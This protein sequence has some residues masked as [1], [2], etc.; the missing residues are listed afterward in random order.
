MKALK[1]DFAVRRP[2]GAWPWAVAISVLSLLTAYQGWRAWGPQARVRVLQEEHESLKRKMDVVS[3]ARRDAI[4]RS[5]VI[6]AYAADAA[7]VAKMAGFPLDRVLQSLESAQVQSVKVTGL[8]ISASEGSVRTELEFADHAAL[9]GY[10]EAL[11]AG[12]PR[13]RWVLLQT[14]IGSAAGAGNV[15]VIVSHW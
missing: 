15:G 3:Q 2:I 4:A 6:P 8:E 1:A 14:Q 11:N 13:A 12:E 5:N 9:L 7:A 10:I